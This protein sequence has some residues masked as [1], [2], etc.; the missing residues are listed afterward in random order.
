M[1]GIRLGL[2]FNQM[3]VEHVKDLTFEM[4]FDAF[5]RENWWKTA[6][7]MNTIFTMPSHSVGWDAMKTVRYLK[8][9]FSARKRSPRPLIIGNGGFKSITNDENDKNTQICRMIYVRFY[10]RREAIWVE[11]RL[12]NP[13]KIELRARY[14]VLAF[15]NRNTNH[16]NGFYYN[17]PFAGYVQRFSASF[18]FTVK[19]N[20][21][22]N[23][24]M[25][26]IV[27]IKYTQ[28]TNEQWHQ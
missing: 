15:F 4:P 5:W 17:S 28:S 2:T 13:I 6:K 14:R 9:I 8:R 10:G 3:L 12:Q 26:G 18:Y 11:I 20:L 25:R 21:F 7:P 19:L 27:L 16:K 24:Y 23:W 22:S 1:L